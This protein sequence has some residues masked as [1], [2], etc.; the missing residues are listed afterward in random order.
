MS[1]GCVPMDEQDKIVNEENSSITDDANPEV[2][3]IDSDRSRP[4][5]PQD[6]DRDVIRDAI[7]NRVRN[8]KVADNVIFYPAK[9]KPTINDTDAKIVA[10]YARVSTNNT[11]QVSSIENQSKYYKELIAKNP[12]WTMQEIYSDEGKSGT[13]M[14]KRT[15]FRRMI[16]D[17]TDKKMD[18]I[19]CAS[20]SRFARNV[21][22]CIKQVKLLET[23]NPSH[24]VGVYFETEDIYT[25]DPDSKQLLSI[26]AL[27]A[28]WESANKSRR[29]ILSYDQR[30]CTGQ[31]PVLDL[32]GYRHTTDGNLIIQEDEALTVRFIYIALYCGYSLKE[33]ADTLTQKQR[34]TLKGRTDWNGQM[35][36]N[37][38]TNERRWGDLS[39]RKTIVIDYTEGKSIKNNQIRDAAY[40]PKHHKGIVSPEIAK[41]VSLSISS[42]GFSVGVPDITVIR[43]GALKG[44]VSVC[45]GW[46]GI[47]LDT[48]IAVCCSVYESDEITRIMR[49]TRIV[50]GKEISKQVQDKSAG[51]VFPRGIFFL[52]RDTPT[53]TFHKNRI[54]FNRQSNI[55]LG[56]CDHIEMLYHPY[57]QMI[58]VRTCDA[59][60]PNRLK[61]VNDNGKFK[62]TVSAKAFTKAI[63]EIMHW[64]D[65]NR[66]RIKGITRERG[67]S[68]LLLFYLDE[69]QI[70][71]ADN[72]ITYP[73]YW[74]EDNIGLCYELKRLRDKVA[75]AITEL[76]ILEQGEIVINP[77]IGDLPSRE[78]AF[79]ELN[80][81]LSMM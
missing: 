70:I 55:K 57:L 5:R 34:A 25:L 49:E 8:S 38:T 77:M 7:R 19:L 48:F 2:V 11:E 54:S 81:L 29:M 51:Y 79:E 59:Y 22:D 45:P 35:V 47:D 43:N 36:K 33:V 52:N 27:L 67:N 56:E 53:L 65:Q 14:K 40:V 37:I 62:G 39:A 75:G 1:K 6:A 3:V 9:P 76:D 69:P 68:K 61:W 26:H 32:L 13:S 80:Q 18:L 78:E 63:Y 20:V 73:T 41:A 58:I 21:S 42:T 64:S 30:I 44:F 74:G 31:Y 66:Y 50:S 60:N 72:N 46:N 17:A 10:V 28:D 71:D 15:E 23:V 16:K 12:N 4:W 24:P